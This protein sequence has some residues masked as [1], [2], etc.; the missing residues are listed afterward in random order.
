[1]V[2]DRTAGASAEQEYATIVAD[3]PWE[4]AEGFNGFGNRRALPY[5][6]MTLD[7]LAALPVPQLLKREGYLFLWS[8]NRH[9]PLAHDLV[10]SWGFSYRQTL[11][12]D[13]GEGSG[14]LGGMFATTSEFVVVAQNIRP[15]T[16][17]HGSRTKRVR[18]P[19]SVLRYPR[20]KGHSTKPDAF[21]DLVETVAPGPYLELFA[22]RKRLGWHAWGNEIESDI[23]VG[24]VA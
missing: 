19:E 23:D 11:T 1:M 18:H 8:T 22:R 5:A 4:Y 16:N 10:R 9:L 2:V 21:L 13:K 15:G 3:P 17:A 12:W 7:E 20:Q 24:L 14:G 6:S